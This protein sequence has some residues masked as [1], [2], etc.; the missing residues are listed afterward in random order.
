MAILGLRGGTDG[1]PNMIFTT[2]ETW[3]PNK[4]VQAYVYVIGA[5]GSGAGGGGNSNHGFSGG[6]AGGCAVSLLKLTAGVTYTAVIGAGG[7]YSGG[8]T[9]A[10]GNAG[11]N[12]TFNGSDIDIMTGNGGSA[13]AIQS[14]GSASGASGGSASGGNLMNNTG[15]ASI[16]SG[17]TRQVSGGGAVGLWDT[18]REG[19]TVASSNDW[20]DG[21]NLSGPPIGSYPTDARYTTDTFVA[22]A[23]F[24]EIYSVTATNL[25]SRTDTVFDVNPSFQPAGVQ[26][27]SYLGDDISYTSNL[28]AYPAPP[29]SGGNGYITN[30]NDYVYA[31]SGSL[32]GGGGAVLATAGSSEG[33]SGKGGMGAVLIFP[34]S[35][36]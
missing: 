14:G 8:S 34:I 13:G 32:G 7:A 28:K 16:A 3:S 23:P 12:T 2:G 10:A 27:Y 17:A 31:G 22:G 21:G 11:G 33:F 36:G 19:T 20:A 6:G 1:I 5:G 29:F 25:R 18:G 26:P 15:G 30:R 4:T 9:Q 35:L 24:P